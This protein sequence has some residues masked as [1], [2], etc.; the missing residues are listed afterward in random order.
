MSRP[1]LF[2]FP[3]AALLAVLF[4]LTGAVGCAVAPDPVVRLTPRHPP[5]A[6]VA[7]QPV[8]TF[9]RDSVRLATAFARQRDNMVG[10]RLEIA[11]DS[12]A[13]L[14]FDPAAV[15]YE[16][17]GG[18]GTATATGRN[19][20]PGCGPRTYVF[21]P[22]ELLLGLE[23][24]AARAK[25]EQESEEATASVFVLLNAVGGAASLANGDTRSA[26]RFVD[27]MDRTSSRSSHAAAAH[28][29]RGYAFANT[30]QSL[31]GEVLRKTTIQPGQAVA[32]LVYFPVHPEAT[33]VY[34]R[35]PLPGAQIRF[36]FEQTLHY[37]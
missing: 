10:V 29:R 2:V 7:G 25:A 23:L 11:N 22:E 37:P 12:G 13:P 17:C 4:A 9:Q 21:N 3:S 5:A 16:A 31:E 1:S 18:T 27:N 33:L 30:R 8:V 6:W 14:I 32:G 35:V 19:G 34:L 24:A 15:S 28:E 36:D 26:D 20:S